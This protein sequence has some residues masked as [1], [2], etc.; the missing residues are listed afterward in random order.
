MQAAAVV[1]HSAGRAR[2]VPMEIELVGVRRLLVAAE[3][4]LQSPKRTIH[5]YIGRTRRR[6]RQRKLPAAT[7]LRESIVCRYRIS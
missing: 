7:V 6:R 2:L 3:L 4:H 5:A 1:I